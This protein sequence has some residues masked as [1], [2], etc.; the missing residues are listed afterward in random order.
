VEDNV[1][2]CDLRLGAQDLTRLDRLATRV[3]GERYGPS[4]PFGYAGA[5]AAGRQ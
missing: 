1:G 5:P 4:G 2:A 3:Q